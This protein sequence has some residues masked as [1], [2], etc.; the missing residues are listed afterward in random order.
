MRLVAPPRR[1]TRS[2]GAVLGCLPELDVALQPSR[3]MLVT[4]IHDVMKLDR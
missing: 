3:D 1:L 4:A 2:D